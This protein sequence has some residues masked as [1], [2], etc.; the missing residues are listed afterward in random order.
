MVMVQWSAL[1]AGLCL[2]L[3]LP[4]ARDALLPRCSLPP[5]LQRPLFVEPSGV[6]ADL[7]FT[8]TGCLASVRSPHQHIEVL[9]TSFFGKVLAIDGDLMLTERDE[10]GYHEMIAHVPLAYRPRAAAVLVIGGGDGGTVGQVLRHRNVRRV[11]VVEI[12]EAVVRVCREH[13]PRL[14]A[15]LSD[16]RVALYFQDGAAWASQRAAELGPPAQQQTTEG[17]FDVAIVDSTDFGASAPLSRASFQR[18]LHRLLAA[19]G[20]LVINLTSL[21]WQLDTARLMVRRQRRIYKYVRVFQ[22]HQPTY[23]SGHYCFM[24]CSD[25]TDPA[26]TAQ[27]P[28][29]ALEARGLEMKYYSR[30]VHEAAF[31]LP[32]FARRAVDGEG[33]EQQRDAPIDAQGSSGQASAAGRQPS[34]ASASAADRPTPAASS[35]A[36]EL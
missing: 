21:S 28:W 18:A 25:T 26:A 4:F 16:S 19:G 24:I 3:F 15:S 17:R 36:D 11:T 12:D 6:G 35:D 7:A 22:M 32:E 20:M 33:Q 23:T 29:A 2:G 14:A 1:V 13:F 9:D 5:F 34:S 27:V 8:L 31:A 30:A 10:F